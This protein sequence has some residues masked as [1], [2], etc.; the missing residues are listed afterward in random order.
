MNI[1][2][3]L[4]NIYKLPASSMEKMLSSISEITYPKG[5]HIYRAHKKGTKFYFIKEGLIRAY[6]NYENKEITFWFG[7]DGDSVFPPD[8]LYE[9]KAGEDNCELLEETTL[10]EI[11][12]EVLFELYATDLYIANL[13]R[14]FAEYE[15]RKTEKLFISRQFKTSL[16]RYQE[17]LNE[18]PE[19]IQRVPLGIIASYLGIS[20]VN[21]SRI[22]GQIR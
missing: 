14:R 21:L 8:M 12:V 10:Y 15:L 3:I 17:L 6:T 5:F 18:F 22:R 16:E 19:I 2:E 7:T 4:D 11:D 20:Q 9:N 13:G 1:E